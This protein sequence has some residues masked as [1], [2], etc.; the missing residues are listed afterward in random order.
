MAKVNEWQS[1]AAIDR[2]MSSGK[3]LGQAVGALETPQEVV[4]D[5]GDGLALDHGVSAASVRARAR[6]VEAPRRRR[7]SQAASFVHIKPATSASGG[8]TR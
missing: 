3:L 1:P 2:E 6:A 4:V 7:W 5:R 8:T